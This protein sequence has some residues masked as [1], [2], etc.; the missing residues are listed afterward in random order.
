MECAGLPLAVDKGAVKMKLYKCP[1]CGATY[2]HDKACNHAV[3]ECGKRKV[4]K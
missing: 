1:K 3:Y 2:T 4:K